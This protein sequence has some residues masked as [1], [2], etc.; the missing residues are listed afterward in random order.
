MYIMVF[1]WRMYMMGVVCGV[2]Q[3]G[4]NVYAQTL[5]QSPIDRYDAQT[6]RMVTELASLQ[7][8]RLIALDEFYASNQTHCAG[9]YIYHF[10]R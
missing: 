7:G 8:R 3:G 1:I 6:R 5:G 2:L 4:D 10:F 9:Q